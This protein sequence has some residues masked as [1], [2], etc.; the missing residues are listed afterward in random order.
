VYLIDEPMAAA[1]GAG[2]PVTEPSGNMIVDIGGGTTE[3]AVISLSGI[4][5]SNSTR[6]GGDKMDEAIIN[7]VKRKYNLLIGE[8]TAELVKISIGTAY[9]IDEVRSMEVKGR[10]LVAG[11]PKILEIKNEEVREALSEP[12][13]AVVESVK[14]ALERTPPELAA[15]IVDKGIVLVGGGALLYNLDVLLRETTSLPVMLAEDPLTA[16]AIGT[17]RTLDELPLLKDVAIRS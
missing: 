6:V 15:D 14:I 3:V 10:D 13:N 4:V 8:R 16:V 2:L 9:S 17:G 1:I 11:V 7:Y 5:Y 12:V